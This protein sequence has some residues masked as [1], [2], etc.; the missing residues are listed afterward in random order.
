MNGLLM[1]PRNGNALRLSHHVP[2]DPNQTVQ[3]KDN[4]MSDDKTKRGWQDRKRINVHEDYELSYWADRFNTSGRKVRNA[5][6][7]VGPMV[8]DVRRY[9]RKQ[10]QVD[11]PRA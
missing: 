10:R 9:L 5:V 6:A 7:A 8:E 11:G 2:A 4:R 3:Q 1:Y